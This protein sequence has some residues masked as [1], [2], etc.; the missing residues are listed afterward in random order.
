MHCPSRSIKAGD[1]APA[2]R[3]T[4]SASYSDPSLALTPFTVLP[5]SMRINESKV[6]DAPNEVLTPNCSSS[7]PTESRAS[8]AATHP[9]LPHQSPRQPYL[10][11][12]LIL[13]FMAQWK[14]LTLMSAFFKWGARL[15]TSSSLSSHSTSVRPRARILS[16][17][18]FK[19]FVSASSTVSS[20][21]GASL[22]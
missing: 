17:L 13:K 15:R 8:R 19:N 3:T 5:S 18:A 4:R 22:D 9:P 12:Q 11:C 1:Q 6:P 7:R 20:N 10:D 14:G 21:Y 16:T 2:A